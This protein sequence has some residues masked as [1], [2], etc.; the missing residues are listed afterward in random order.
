VATKPVDFRRGAD[1]LAA[2]A[3]KKLQRDPFS[4]TI[5]VPLEAGGPVEGFGLGW[6]R[7]DFVLE[8]A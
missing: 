5:F 8:A 4:G 7:P 2:L 3:K 6:F 1:S